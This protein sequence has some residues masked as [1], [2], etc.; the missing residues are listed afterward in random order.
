[1][2]AKPSTGQ[3]FTISDSLSD[4]LPQDSE[5]SSSQSQ[6]SEWSESESHSSS[7][8]FYQICDTLIHLL[9][10]QPAEPEIYLKYD[11]LG[12]AWY[13]VYYPATGQSNCFS[14]ENELRAWLKL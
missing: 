9:I 2:N 5:F 14:S 6:L 13:Y 1:M 4:S 8:W 12:Q 10:P 11:R 7:N 3:E